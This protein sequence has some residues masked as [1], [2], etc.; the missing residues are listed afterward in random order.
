MFV[1]EYKQEHQS[2]DTCLVK[3]KEIK[4]AR[5]RQLSMS[6]SENAGVCIISLCAQF[7]YTCCTQRYINHGVHSSYFLC[8]TTSFQYLEK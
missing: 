6:G 5:M 4:K 7:S 2:K 1:T 3:N 8:V